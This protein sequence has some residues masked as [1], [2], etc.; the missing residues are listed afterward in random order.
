MLHIFCDICIVA[1]DK[2]RRPNTYFDKVVENLLW[3]PSKIKPFMPSLKP[4]L[5]TN[6]MVRKQTWGLGE[7]N[8]FWNWCRVE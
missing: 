8:D 2:G 4:N 3:L 6:G 5:K 1:I 7:K